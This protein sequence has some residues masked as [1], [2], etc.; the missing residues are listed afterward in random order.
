MKQKEPEREREN[1]KRRRQCTDVV[2]KNTVLKV[3]QAKC[4]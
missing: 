2:N 1:R 4:L 3:S